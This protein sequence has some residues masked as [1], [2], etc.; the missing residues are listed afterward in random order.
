M[1]IFRYLNAL[2]D[3]N[4]GPISFAR[5]GTCCAFQHNPGRLGT[6]QGVLDV[7][8]IYHD[9]F[10]EPVRLYFNTLEFEQPVAP[11]GLLYQ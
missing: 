8:L 5:E 1:E 10:D 11:L 4:G 3:P 6:G 2:L 7:Y 9:G